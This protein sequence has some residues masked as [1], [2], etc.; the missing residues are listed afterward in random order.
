M[1]FIINNLYW[2][3][4]TIFTTILTTI[5]I[6]VTYKLQKKSLQSNS[7]IDIKKPKTNE[8]K[9]PITNRKSEEPKQKKIIKKPI[10]NWIKIT[11]IVVIILILA[12]VIGY[13]IFV[14]TNSRFLTIKEGKFADPY[15]EYTITL[16]N[17]DWRIDSKW[18]N[19]NW[20]IFSRYSDNYNLV[21]TIIRTRNTNSKSVEESTTYLD[22][23]YL[24]GVKI[25]RINEENSYINIS[26]EKTKMIEFL[27]TF[28]KE[29]GYTFDYGYGKAYFFLHNNN[30]K[31]DKYIIVLIS[32][33]DDN[34]IAKDSF[35]NSF[36][37]FDYIL[38]N[39]ILIY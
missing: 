37:D 8:N 7:S 28:D 6:I 4:P 38:K 9:A 32:E 15:L 3:V 18:S 1:I 39:F 27:A 24:D 25:N 11:I 5:S 33:S 12:F 23:E 34:K 13:I 31:F 10:K 14:S 20:M 22:Y 29:K 26:G 21:A 16:P 35:N 2:I 36:Q 30:N 19:V 17:N